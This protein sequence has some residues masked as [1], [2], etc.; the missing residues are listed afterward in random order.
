MIA[1]IACAPAYADKHPAGFSSHSLNGPARP[2]TKDGITTFQIFDKRC[3]KKDYGDGRG[4]NDCHNGNVRS[5]LLGPERKLGQSVD[6]SFDLWV[7]PG[8]GYGGFFNNHATGFLPE[9]MGQP[10]A[11][12]QLGRALP[13]QFPLHAEARQHQGRHFPRPR[14][15]APERFGNWVTFSM[16]ISWAAEIG[17]DRR[18]L[19]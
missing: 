17:L 16:K 4:E 7:D 2:V 3:S 13:P 15:Q 9:F 8:F 10:T 5:D 19:R 1:A 14:C 12:S 11:H 6:Y 18:Q